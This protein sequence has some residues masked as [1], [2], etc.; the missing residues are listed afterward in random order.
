MKFVASL[1]LALA[2]SAVAF[3]PT[4]SV[5]SSSTRLFAD[6]AVEAKGAAA[7]SALTKDVT[8]VFT[9][10]DVDGFLPHRYP[11]AL[12]DKVVEYEAGK[13]AVGMK[14]VTKVSPHNF[15]GR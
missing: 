12:V 3:A 8:A 7:I 2:S 11:F 4:T 6:V 15:C 10:E 5:S 9:S 14:C 1:L 13:R